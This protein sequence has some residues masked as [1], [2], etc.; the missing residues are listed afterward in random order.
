MTTS[1]IRDAVPQTVS[2][3]LGFRTASDGPPAK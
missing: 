2:E 1:A 3:T